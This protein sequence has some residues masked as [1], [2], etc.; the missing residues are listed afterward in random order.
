MSFLDVEKI[1]KKRSELELAEKKS[2]KLNEE[3]FS[4]SN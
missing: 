2:R 4:I 3:I 1:E